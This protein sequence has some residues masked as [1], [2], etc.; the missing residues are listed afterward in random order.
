[1]TKAF[2][3]D[4]RDCRVRSSRLDQRAWMPPANERHV[5]AK[6]Q[7][8]FVR[9]TANGDAK[10]FEGPM[11]RP[12]AHDE[13]AAVLEVWERIAPNDSGRKAKRS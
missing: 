11:A 8:E 13:N 5:G 12:F 6:D 4:E 10:A 9:C 2:R 3:G 1:M 7:R